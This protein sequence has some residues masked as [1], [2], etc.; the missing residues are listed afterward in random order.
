MDGGAA[1]GAGKADTAALLPSAPAAAFCWP[2]LPHAARARTRHPA[3]KTLPFM[4]FLPASDLLCDRFPDLPDQPV[5]I[6]I[7][8]IEMRR[9]PHPVAAEAEM[10]LRLGQPL[11]D[12][13]A[14]PARKAQRQIMRRARRARLG[15]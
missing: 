9:D 11:F 12:L 2:D 13:V 7:V 15:P 4:F 5:G 10:D 6:L 8:I 1:P 3:I 14:E